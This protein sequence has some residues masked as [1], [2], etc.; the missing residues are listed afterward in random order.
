MPL[1]GFAF[2]TSLNSLLKSY[3]SDDDKMN[4]MFDVF[5]TVKKKVDAV[6]L[7]GPCNN[8]D[9]EEASNVYYNKKNWKKN[10]LFSVKYQSNELKA[11]PAVIANSLR[12]KDTTQI[13]LLPSVLYKLYLQNAYLFGTGTCELYAVVGA[14]FLATEFD[15]DLSIETLYSNESHTYIRVHTEPEYIMDFWGS[16]ACEYKDTLS[17]NEFFGEQFI[18]NKNSST[19][20]E[21]QLNSKELLNMGEDVFSEKNT[22]QRTRFINKVNK[23]VL[24][25]SLDTE[26]NKNSKIFSNF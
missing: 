3:N 2:M 6:L 15:L 14:Y 24:Q 7:F 19:Q 11:L 17:W 16:M 26:S 4:F 1:S 25:E 21:I 12:P 10:T 5:K 8:K 13:N 20:K 18:R 23:L 9:A 22:L